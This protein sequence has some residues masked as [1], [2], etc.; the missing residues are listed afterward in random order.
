RRSSLAEPAVKLAELIAGA[1]LQRLEGDLSAE[2]MGLSY[3]SRKT[4]RGDLFFSTARQESEG[5]R[6]IQ[7]AL[8][9]GARAVVMRHAWEV[10][11]RPAVTIIQC[12]RPRLLMGLAASRFF[13]A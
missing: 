10:G 3:D 5:R 4:N 11:A 6:H 9:R 12:E 7:Q 8:N 1:D 2:I 13:D